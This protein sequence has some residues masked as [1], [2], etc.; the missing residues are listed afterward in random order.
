MMALVPPGK[1]D[2]DMGKYPK[3]VAWLEGLKALKGWNEVGRREGV[4][5]QT[6]PAR[7][8]VYS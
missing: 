2:L 5:G 4:V 7:V 8:P 3:V 1:V 6:Q